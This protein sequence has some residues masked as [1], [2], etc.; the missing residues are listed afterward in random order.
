MEAFQAGDDSFAG[1]HHR[2]RSRC[3]RAQRRLDGDRARRAHGAG[4]TASAARPGRARQ[5]QNRLRAAVRNSAVGTGA[6]A[7]ERSYSKSPTASKSRVRICC[8]AGRENYWD[9]ARAACR[10]C[11]SPIWNAIFNCWDRRAITRSA[12]SN[13]IPILPRGMLSGGWGVGRRWRG[14]ECCAGC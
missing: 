12:V 13:R 9:N 3:G 1:R 6:S 8:C 10:C 14:V 4:A 2:D 7:A 11:A 5:P